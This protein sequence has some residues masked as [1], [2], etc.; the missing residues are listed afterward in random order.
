MVGWQ[1][2]RRRQKARFIDAVWIVI[3]GVIVGA[4]VSLVFGSSILGTL[5]QLMVWLALVRRFFDATW[6]QAMVIAILAVVIFIVVS[7]ILGLLGLAVF[8]LLT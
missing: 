5:I 3:A 1:A 4:I 8:S 6:G 7:L 2:D